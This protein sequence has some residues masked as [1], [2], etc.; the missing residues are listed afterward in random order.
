MTVC[1][2][3]LDFAKTFDCVNHQILLNKLVHYGLSGN[4]LKLLSLYLI[5]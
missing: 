2:A 3:F 1:G 4:A 5:N